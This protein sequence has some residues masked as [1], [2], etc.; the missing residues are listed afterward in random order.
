MLRKS[1]ENGQL[2]RR[3]TLHDLFSIAL[4]IFFLVPMMSQQI[5]VVADITFHCRRELG[6]PT[7]L[8]PG[9]VCEPF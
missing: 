5:R 4:Y 1:I 7:S 2:I 9:E 3:V 8:V 6:P